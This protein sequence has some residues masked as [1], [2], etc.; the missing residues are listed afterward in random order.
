MHFLRRRTS[1]EGTRLARLA[2][3]LL[4]QEPLTRFVRAE[5]GEELES[6]TGKATS[7]TVA[8]ACASPNHGWMSE[9]EEKAKPILTPMIIGQRVELNDEEQRIVSTWAV[10]TAIV[11]QH[12][13]PA[14]LSV[15]PGDAELLRQDQQPSRSTQVF[16]AVQDATKYD[17]YYYANGLVL[18]VSVSL[19]LPL[20][21]PDWAGSLHR[22]TV[23]HR[24]ARR[25]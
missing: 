10:K 9:L 17:T 15:P 24:D 22:V 21:L 1:D 23:T 6:W 11:L 25:V 19:R 5:G 12:A 16:L 20:P 8:I 7:P 13:F 4:P 2:K 3:T 18:H 14:R